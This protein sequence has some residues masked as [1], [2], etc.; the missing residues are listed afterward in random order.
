MGL[1]R[2][3]LTK[4]IGDLHA[5]IIEPGARCSRPVM[6]D[7][8]R[9]AGR[10]HA[11]RQRRSDCRRPASR[12]ARCRHSARR[13]ADKGSHQTPKASHRKASAAEPRGRPPGPKCVTACTAFR[14]D[15]GSTPGKIEIAIEQQISAECMPGWIASEATT[16]P[17]G[18][19][20]IG[21]AGQASGMIAA[22][23][24]TGVRASARIVA[25]TFSN[26][27]LFEGVLSVDVGIDLD[28]VVGPQARSRPWLKGFL[29]LPAHPPSSH[30]C[31]KPHWPHREP[32]ETIFLA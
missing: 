18:I 17:T 13:R 29:P 27:V 21:P 5:L 7:K 24:T 2:Q 30:H 28:I 4:P 25:L 1:G 20:P 12:S 8:S 23:R 16:P 3:P 15:F 6:G 32:G 22:E 19:V 14:S 11:C 31:S 26:I 10:L 9:F